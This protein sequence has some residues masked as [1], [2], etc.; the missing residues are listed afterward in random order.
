MQLDEYMQM[1]VI[2]RWQDYYQLGSNTIWG[3]PLLTMS[4]RELIISSLKY[5]V[6]RMVSSSLVLPGWAHLI[7]DRLDEW[8][9]DYSPTAAFDVDQ[10]FPT[11]SG[12]KQE[13]AP[14]L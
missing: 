10:I 2:A 6:W 8:C 4:H 14:F 3:R 5:Y 12:R 1:V 11:L 7:R 9:R 13:E